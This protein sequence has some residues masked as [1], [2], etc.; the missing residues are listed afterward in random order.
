MIKLYYHPSP[1]PA[2]IA[3]YL[4]ET[5]LPYELVPVDT[6][7]GEQHLP[8]FLAI[9]PNAKTPALTDGDAVVFDSTAILLY[10][11]EKTG[12]YLPANTPVARAQMLSWM[13]FVATGIGPYSGQC[14]HFKHFA[15]EP[16]EYAVN[17][18][19][20]EAWRHWQLIDNQLA[21]HPY[22]LG[23]EY[24]VVDMAVWGWARAV[25][26]ILGAEAWGRLPNVKRLLDE[27]NARPAAQ[28]AEAIKAQ[29]SFKTD[30][31]EAARKILFPQNA[32]LVS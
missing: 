26:F 4:E 7:K 21:K 8:A 6:R 18:Y 20:F 17:R 15:P 11:A 16:K 14:V 25:P 13:M 3:L 22:M 24:T 32:R 2:K 31:D 5:G 27:I 19:D 30:M 1:N 23:N 12:K 29:H 10:L 9:N 28:R